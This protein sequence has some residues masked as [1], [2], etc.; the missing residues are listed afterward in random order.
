MQQRGGAGVATLRAARGGKK[1]NS[2]KLG[3]GGQKHKSTDK[4][5]KFDRRG[6]RTRNLKELH[7]RNYEEERLN[8]S[9]IIVK[10]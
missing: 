3:P 8:R 6:Q 7:L 5:R 9:A 4:S 1:R 2:S 10:L